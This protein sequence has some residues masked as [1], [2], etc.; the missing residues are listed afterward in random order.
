MPKTQLPDDDADKG[1]A[2]IPE[3]E[4]EALEQSEQEDTEE[5][6]EEEENKE[7]TLHSRDLESGV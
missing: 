6:G 3:L 2:A 5:T 4:D 1:N 7:G